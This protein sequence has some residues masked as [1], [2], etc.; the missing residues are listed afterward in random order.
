M[1]FII[2]VGKVLKIKMS[3][4]L[5]RGDARMAQQLLDSPQVTAGLQHVRREGVSEHMR[6]Y[7]EPRTLSFGP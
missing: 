5:S 7:R 3:I 4:D 2:Y 6:V 1:R